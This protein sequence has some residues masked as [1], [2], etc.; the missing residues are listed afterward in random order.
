[1][2]IAV[3]PDYRGGL[4]HHG[5]AFTVFDDMREPERVLSPPESYARWP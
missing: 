3:D 1:M 5:V 2:T 4:I